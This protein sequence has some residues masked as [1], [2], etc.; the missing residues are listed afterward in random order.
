MVSLVMVEEKIYASNEIK[1]LT[2]G[3]YYTIISLYY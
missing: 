3:I 2:N 1:N